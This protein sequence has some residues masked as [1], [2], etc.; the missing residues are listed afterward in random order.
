MDASTYGYSAT[1]LA[2]L[3]GVHIDTARRWKR[4]GRVPAQIAPLIAL[5]TDGDLGVITP[6]W[7]G[8]RI[9]KD[10]I[11]TPEG[12]AITPGDL[13]AIPYRTQQLRELQRQLAEPKQWQL[14]G[15]GS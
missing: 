13:R 5:R 14:F 6:T 9:Q 7:S 4:A 8:F 3:T 11:W 1:V 10:Q 2:R 12:S 15:H